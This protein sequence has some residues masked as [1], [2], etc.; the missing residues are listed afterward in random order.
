MVYAIVKVVNGN[1]FI[2]AE[3]FTDLNSAKVSF[4][5]LCQNLWNAPD[6][7]RGC[8]ALV[9]ENMNVVSSDGITQYREFIVH[10][11]PNPEPEPTPEPEE[12]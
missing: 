12:E 6:V 9:D 11:A 3:G 10:D 8:V 2:D 5:G 1:Y 4:H 7:Y